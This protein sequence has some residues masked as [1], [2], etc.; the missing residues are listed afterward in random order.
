MYILQYM[1]DSIL[2]ASLT[3]LAQQVRVEA[4]VVDAEVEITLP[5]HSA[6]PVTAGVIVHQ[7]LLVRHS[8]QPPKLGG[9]FLEL[10]RVVVLLIV[11]IFVVL[12][13]DA[14]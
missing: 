1:H 2:G 8:E 3:L 5:G 12:G 10:V 14:L 7:L 6:L 11:V 9:C 13:N 4:E